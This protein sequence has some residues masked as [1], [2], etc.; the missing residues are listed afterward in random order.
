MKHLK[1][2]F[3]A[4][5]M[6]A[7]AVG[8]LNAQYVTT[9]AKIAIPS[10][11]KGI[12][13]A[14]PRTVI[15]LDF[16]IEEIESL[17]GP[18]SRYVRMVG[19]DD[20][21]TENETEYRIADIKMYTYSEADPNATFFVAINTKKGESS[22]FS[23]TSNGIL[24]GVGVKV[25]PYTEKPREKT[26]LET[27]S[28]GEKTFKYQYASNGNR[29]EEQ[30]ARSAADMISKIREE[31]IKL[32]T[33]YQETAFVAETYRQMY[34]D[35]DGME[36]EYLSLFIG[37]KIVTT[38]VK[39]IYVTPSKEV[40]SQTIGKFSATKGLTMGVTGEGSPIVVH[41]ISLNTTGTINELSRSAVETL[42]HENKLFYRIPEA[43]Y[44][45]VNMDDETLYENR[46]TINQYGVF[47][48]APLGKSKMTLNPETGQIINISTE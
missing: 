24:H 23:L 4:I 46:T 29:G 30:M 22:D 31:K 35:L 36:K 25:Q 48:M 39:T 18:Y 16:V 38:T 32:L 8:N 7:F 42:S 26:V 45:T 34:S 33:G 28:S 3:L 15:Q 1:R 11:Q 41:A 17:E 44:V 43:A 37:K 14:L 21:I 47:M 12:Y 40:P 10:Q 20:Y 2:T 13:Y 6:L 9:H 5:A 19:A 27:V